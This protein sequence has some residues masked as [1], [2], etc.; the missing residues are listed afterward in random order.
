MSFNTKLRNFFFT[1][2]CKNQPTLK[3]DDMVETEESEI[4]IDDS[5]NKIS[6]VLLLKNTQ[7]SCELINNELTRIP[8]IRKIFTDMFPNQKILDYSKYKEVEIFY[9]KKN[10]KE[11]YRVKKLNYKIVNHFFDKVDIKNR[12]FEYDKKSNLFFLNY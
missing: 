12:H 7:H 10:L 6:I 3:L 8:Q 2:F 4:D 5:Y 9:N 11:I 1:I